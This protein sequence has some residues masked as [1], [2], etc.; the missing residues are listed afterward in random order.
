MPKGLLRVATLLAAMAIVAVAILPCWKNADAQV[1]IL[2]PVDGQIKYEGSGPANSHVDLSIATTFDTAVKGKSITIRNVSLSADSYY[3]VTVSPAKSITV[4][5][6]GIPLLTKRYEATGSTVSMT[7]GKIEFMGVVI[8]G[9]YDVTAAIETA[10]SSIVNVEIVARYKTDGNGK[11]SVLLNTNGLPDGVYSIK[12]GGTEVAKA[13][14]GV[15]PPKSYTLH[16]NAGWNLVSIPITP[17]SGQISD[18][19]SV[20]QQANINVIWDYNGGDWKYWT[21]EPGYTNQ[22]SSLSP[23]RGYYFYCYS[24]MSVT[25]YGSSPS[26]PISMDSL[27]SGWNL[28]GFPSSS[29]ASI[30]SLYGTAGVVWK[31]DNENWYYW[32]TEPGYTNQFEMLTPG[33][34]Y[35]IYKY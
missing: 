18:I 33:L 19:F 25:I 30:A 14:L 16:F 2:T 10:G 9:N 17:E 35:W 1:A 13:Y 26:G 22:F 28:I 12:Q 20:S 31:M 3:H 11:Y 27:S 21:T 15:E 32:T 24:P 5:S 6:P 4:S 23:S 34:G 8:T 7:I 29:D